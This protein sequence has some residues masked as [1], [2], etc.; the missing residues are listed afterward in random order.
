MKLMDALQLAGGVSG[1]A[2]LLGG[3]MWLGS[4]N[5]RIDRME[6]DVEKLAAPA[7]KRDICVGLSSAWAKVLPKGVESKE[8][9]ALNEQMD[10]FGCAALAGK[11]ELPR[12]LAE[13]ETAYAAFSVKVCDLTEEERKLYHVTPEEVAKCDKS[14]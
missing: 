14:N 5:A 4:L 7:G 12:L 10:R 1:V 9:I 2:A 13:D 11:A 6:K 8:A 3:A